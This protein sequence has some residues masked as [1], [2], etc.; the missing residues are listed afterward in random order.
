[1]S[2]RR[3]NRLTAFA[4]A[5]LAQP[6]FADPVEDGAETWVSGID[7]RTAGTEGEWLLD[8]D[9]VYSGT[10][11]GAV[12]RIE[13]PPQPGTSPV[14]FVSDATKQF[15]PK[16]GR[17]HVATALLYPGDGTSGQVVVSIVAPDGTVLGSQRIDKVIRWPSK[18]QRDFDLAYSMIE[19]G[20]SEMLREARTIL[21]GL[22]ARNPRHDEAYVELARVAMKTN[23]G[24]EGLHQA[25]TLLDSALEIRPESVNA[26][27]LLGYVYAHQG[28]FSQ[29]EQ[30]FAEAAREDPPNVWL[31]T[32]WGELHEM[33]GRADLAEIKYREALERPLGTKWSFSAR[34]NAYFALLRLLEGRNDY[35]GMETLHE[36]RIEEYGAGGCYTAEYARFKL[37]VRQD[38]EGA[39]E[40]ARRA[41]NGSCAA[42]QARQVLGLASYAK[43]AKSDG[44]EAAEAL[45]QARVFLP[46]GA[47]MFYLLA[48]DPST[49]PAA[50]KLIATGEAVDQKDNAG[51]TAL[52]FA[53]RGDEL[54]TAERLLALGAGWR[55]PVTVAAVPVALMPVLDG[56][57]PAIALLRRA[58]VDYSKLQYRGATAI[59]WA[60][61]AGDDALLRALVGTEGR[62]L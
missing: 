58:G 21:E 36:R 15:P 39:I 53:L 37:N 32:N 44:D 18:E 14:G 8:F 59:D 10:P 35:D 54:A 42:A 25:R 43:W 16:P 12:F 62:T 27:I 57:L 28:R 7:V 48:S 1:M 31:W 2:S 24:P 33:Q 51:M 50:S 55:T 13:T 47:S 34:G 4:L 60:K 23:W 6:L 29:A 61:E 5:L 17:H 19:N 45:N 22:I 9:Y 40:L 46:A 11:P 3:F 56:N 52:A 20:R 26:E 38:T 30:L 41:L 49:I